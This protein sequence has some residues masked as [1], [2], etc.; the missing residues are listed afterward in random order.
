M[1]KNLPMKLMINLFCRL[2]EDGGFIQFSEL[3]EELKKTKIDKS[4]FMGDEDNELL[5]KLID[6]II[7]KKYH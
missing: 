5:L 1:K 3:I 7:K 4:K 6:S 2:W